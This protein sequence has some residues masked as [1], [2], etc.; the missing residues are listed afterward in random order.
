M[1]K[2]MIKQGRQ[3]DHLAADIDA[4]V[5]SLP[6]TWSIITGAIKWR[7]ANFAFAQ[8]RRQRTHTPWPPP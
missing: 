6:T 7:D 8:L 2:W 3:L 5:D 1:I 4:A